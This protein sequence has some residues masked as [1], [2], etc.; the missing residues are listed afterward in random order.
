MLQIGPTLAAALLYLR[1][2][3]RPR[4]LWIDAVCIN[5]S[6]LEEQAQQVGQMGA[7]RSPPTRS[8]SST[9]YP[10]TLDDHRDT[11][12]LVGPAYMDGI[13]DGEA[14]L[15]SLP[16]GYAV[17]W[18]VCPSEQGSTPVF[19]NTLTGEMCR[20]DPRVDPDGE[21]STTQQEVSGRYWALTPPRLRERGVDI[22]EV[23]IV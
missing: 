20:G 14:L 23:D 6:N 15:G 17:Q 1:H 22:K 19:S 11:F 18:R 2:R 13:M 10:G 5:Q 3:D 7:I 21:P 9:P 16:A 8:S 12:F 4:N